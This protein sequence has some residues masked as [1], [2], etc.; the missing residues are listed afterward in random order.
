M[1][2]IM[3]SQ[4]N[5][6]LDYGIIRVFLG[7]CCWP[8]HDVINYGVPI[9]CA[10]YGSVTPGRSREKPYLDKFSCTYIDSKR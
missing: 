7:A 4:N 6:G 2:S 10:F 3:G 5:I 8:V 1:G 9:I